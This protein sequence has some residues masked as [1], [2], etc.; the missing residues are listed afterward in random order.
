M[1]TMILL[2]VGGTVIS[3]MVG[4]FWHSMAMPTGSLHMKYLGFDVLSEAEKQAKIKEAEP[5][6]PKIYAAQM[7]LSFLTSAFV[8][9]VITTSVENGVPF[10][11]AIVFPIIGWL[12]FVVPNVGS[13][14][15]WG[16][17][18]SEIAWK[19]FFS[20]IGYVLVTILLIALMTGLF[21]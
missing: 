3:I 11:M 6:M 10:S 9:G 13:A 12:C 19:K 16:N 8:V 15:L 17:C 4:A 18:P 1:L 20:D 2:I 14:I 7:F 5:K 21:V